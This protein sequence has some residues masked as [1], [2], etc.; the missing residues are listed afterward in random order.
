MI[1]ESDFGPNL[2]YMVSDR[3]ISLLKFSY[4]VLVRIS[5]LQ[6][7]SLFSQVHTAMSLGQWPPP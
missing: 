6:P 1:A 5:H 2:L 3:R 4:P 7:D